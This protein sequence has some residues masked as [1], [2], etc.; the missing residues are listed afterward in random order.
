MMII[1]VRFMGASLASRRAGVK[2]GGGEAP[3]TVETVEPPIG[4][5][6]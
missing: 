6:S 2:A 1:D 4:A 3:E 5:C